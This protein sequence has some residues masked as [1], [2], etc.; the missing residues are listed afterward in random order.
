MTT[1][2]FVGGASPSVSSS[3]TDRWVE[4]ATGV[5]L[6]T[7]ARIA[8]NGNRPVYVS[9]AQFFVAG[10][11]A[12]RQLRLSVGGAA[13]AITF[14]SAGSAQ[15]TGNIAINGLFANGGTQVVRIEAIP[16]GSYYFGRASGTSGSIDYYGTTYG[17]LAGQV[18]YYEVP[19]APLSVTASQAT[20][21]NAVNVSWS[22]PSNN[23]GSAVTS[24]TIRW[25]Y[26]SDF[27][28][29]T[30]ISTGNT[31]TSY[32]ITGLSYGSVVYVKVAAVN[33]VATAAATTSVY[34]SSAN[35]YLV[36]PN[37]PLNGWANFGTLAGLTFELVHTSITALI[38]ET[39][40]QRKATSNT[41]TG[42]YTTGN[43]GI[44]KT[45]TDLVPGRSYTISGKAILLTAAVPGNIYRFAVN[46]IGNGSSVTLT[47][48]TVGATIPSYTF[49]ASATT[50]TIQIELAET[51]SA[52][53]GVMEH[54]AFYDYALTRTAVDLAY[55]VQD[56]ERSASLVDHFDL[57]T[58]S[59]GAFWWVDKLNV[60]QFTQNFNST[61][62]ACTFSDVIAD[63]NLYYTGI[64]TSFDTSTVINDITFDNIGRRPTTLAADAY[65]SFNVA[66]NENS[67]T[68]VANWGARKYN[69]TTNLYT[70]E[71]RQNLIPNPTAAYGPEYTF[72][73]ADTNRRYL[74]AELSKVAI[75]GTG[76]LPVGTTQPAI[77]AGGFVVTAIAGAN[78]GS[79]VTLYTGDENPTTFGGQS[80]GYF[81]VN[82]STQ[83]TAS[84]YVRTGINN[85]SGATARIDINFIN[86]TGGSTLNV[87]GTAVSIGS[88]G[89]T[90]VSV[91][92]TATA[93]TYAARLAIV[94]GHSGANN[95]GYRYYSTCAQF[96]AASTAS[97]FFSGDT[98]D[99]ATYVYEWQG[100][101]GV[102]RSIRYLNQMDTRTGELL[103]Q[104]ATPI[105]RVQEL[106]YN[107]AQ[108]PTIAA[109]IDIGSLV[110][111]VFKSNNNSIT[112]TNLVTNPN[113]ETNTTNWSA[114][115]GTI[116]RVTTT[117]QTGTY[118][119]QMNG[120]IDSDLSAGYLRNLSLSVGTAYRGGLW[121]RVST[122]TQALTLS[123][124]AGLGAIANQSFTA[125]TTWQFIQTASVTATGTTAQ[126]VITGAGVSANVFVD[127]AI[128]ET[129]AN[130]TS[131]FFDGNTPDAGNT[132]YAW[133]GTANASTSTATTTQKPIYRV[134][135][136][137]HDINPER[138]MSTLQ[139][140]KV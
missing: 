17:S 4:T 81:P 31:S 41:T 100:T 51:V 95:T 49:T 5:N 92:G 39:G 3:F 99:D 53:V 98:T 119:L 116:S 43:F 46:G 128:I 122:G 15:A 11:G 109:T 6:P 2:A 33:V 47:S 120:D 133:T 125:T 69:L 14:A 71:N 90:R 105:T 45:Y 67:P 7:N 131:S 29:S 79:L 52:I 103:T 48:T 50:H 8:D 40:I 115:L 36:P 76:N 20:T 27:A 97:T 111:V 101:R 96:E 124:I 102:S 22:A 66:W 30:T 68:S 10:R 113:F 9:T 44:E 61:I 88:T 54:V 65:E 18:E 70:A 82:A 12:A 112:R 118:C 117:P 59:V 85:T 108:N 121:V 55:R 110:E 137:S 58:Q 1:L 19:S 23:G 139:V 129:T 63:G 57:A 16:T 60:T 80:T 136:I 34:S 91:T 37:L 32:K 25:S 28:S 13:N 78:V 77:N 130:W 94:F 126:L 134:T 26:T 86:D 21:E 107:T 35:A 42:S 38:P 83:Y 93:T 74:R 24:Y 138:W 72:V 84:V 56:N 132:D 64:K 73:Q 123:L 135:G 140:A 106:T 62:P 104:F 127:S 114:D 89:W 75:G 87:I